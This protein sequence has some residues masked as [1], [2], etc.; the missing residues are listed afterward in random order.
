MP[1]PT[2]IDRLRALAEAAKVD[3]FGWYRSDGV[4]LLYEDGARIAALPGADARLIAA[5]SPDAL[6]SLLDDLEA[7]RGEN[8][9][10]RE[11]TALLLV[12]PPAEARA[13]YI[14]QHAA[15][16]HRALATE[17]DLEQALGL[18]AEVN[19]L[20]LDLLTGRGITDRRG[21]HDLLQAARDFLTTHPPER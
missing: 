12:S 3:A 10:L 20:A 2:D 16:L 4:F 11:E 9:R 21:S 17:A 19:V 15:V 5:A 14:K 7:L 8:E 13:S 6:L 1:E 18:L